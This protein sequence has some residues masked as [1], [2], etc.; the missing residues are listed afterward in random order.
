MIEKIKEMFD[1]F[2]VYYEII[3]EKEI[4]VPCPADFSKT[5]LIPQ[6]DII[7]NPDTSCITDN[8]YVHILEDDYGELSWLVV[9]KDNLHK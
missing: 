9:I 2:D 4:A 8:S 6:I 1:T 7:K 5:I 3:S